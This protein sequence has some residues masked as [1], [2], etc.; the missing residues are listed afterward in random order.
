MSS[1]RFH[2]L[3]TEPLLTWA[4]DSAGIEEAHGSLPELLAALSSDCVFSLNTRP[5]H[6]V[7]VMAFLGQLA[8]IALVKQGKTR[9][10]KSAATWRT[11]LQAIADGDAWMLI[12]PEGKHAFMQPHVRG[13]EP[14]DVLHTP[15]DLDV[16]FHQD[17]EMTKRGLQ[18]SKD[19]EAWVYALI[20]AQTY[21]AYQKGHSC[22]A[23]MGS[24][25]GS[26]PYVNVVPGF[27]AWQQF[28]R[29]VKLYLDRRGA[30]RLGFS[31]SGCALLWTYPWKSTTVLSP[32]KLAP[33]FIE[34]VRI[35][36]LLKTS[37][38]VKAVKAVK[39]VRDWTTLTQK[40]V[41]VSGVV[42]DPMI[43]VV[44]PNRKQK[45]STQEEK[46]PHAFACK[47]GGFSDAVLLRMLTED[48]FHAQL[49][50]QTHTWKEG[51]DAWVHAAAIGGG[52]CRTLGVHNRYVQIPTR[53][54]MSLG[55]PEARAAVAKITQ[56]LVNV[57]AD[58]N[59]AFGH[60]IVHLKLAKPKRG[61]AW[62]TRLQRFSETELL[63]EV[64][65]L[66]ESEDAANGA[67]ALR[68]RKRV[69]DVADRLLKE[70]IQAR[71]KAYRE[72]V[73]AQRVLRRAMPQ[74]K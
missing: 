13:A 12:T 45:A 43:P 67:G 32:A 14:N 3:L 37:D 55:E 20:V 11:Y 57:S 33:N 47:E 72:I 34:T 22:V 9:L 68:W 27:A 48:G 64:S 16:L 8:A 41:G 69:Y 62:A 51:D 21:S 63:A 28:Q 17:E 19:L 23:R 40:D 25:Y 35:L 73:E 24:G 60:A 26:R 1:E 29:D 66:V 30:L 56:E 38:G 5:H 53:L 49:G 36:K 7:G 15:D 2:D 18:D 52:Q 4:T 10:P 31:E 46:V 65:R 59:K 44:V 71:P 42:G 70:A 39:G 58:V 61:H 54:R 6:Y 74:T 50:Q